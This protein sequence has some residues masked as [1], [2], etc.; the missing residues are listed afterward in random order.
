MYIQ[1]S[2]NQ[3]VFG[4]VVKNRTVYC[5]L[6]IT[7]EKHYPIKSNIY[8]GITYNIV[9]VESVPDDINVYEYYYSNNGFQYV[10]TFDEMKAQ[11]QLENKVAFKNYL[12]NQSITWTDGKQYGV[13]EK[14]SRKS[15]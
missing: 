3:T 1:K 5:Y 13:T 2:K 9:Q 12:S 14:I 4:F 6:C 11:K 15:V 7:C 8:N 10:Q